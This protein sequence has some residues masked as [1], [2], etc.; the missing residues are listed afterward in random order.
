MQSNAKVNS[1]KTYG[2]HSSELNFMEHV[3]REALHTFPDNKTKLEGVVIATKGD[4]LLFGPFIERLDFP[5]FIEP[6]RV[7]E[8]IQRSFDSLWGIA[9]LQLWQLQSS[10]FSSP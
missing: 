4:M 1:S 3:L 5:A 6:E 2:K 7:G 8:I 9:S 10:S